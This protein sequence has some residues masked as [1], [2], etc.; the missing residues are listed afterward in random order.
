MLES[1][2]GLGY[3][4]IRERFALVRV[5]V[6]HT[7]R[8]PPS[9]RDDEY[10]YVALSRGIEEVDE[11]GQSTREAGAP[12]TITDLA[13]FAKAL[14][15]TT[16][17]VVMGER[18]AV[19]PGPQVAV[20]PAPGIAQDAMVVRGTL[21]RAISFETEPGGEMS[22]WKGYDFKNLTAEAEAATKG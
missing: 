7:F 18:W 2:S 21:P 13:A 17:V 15:T 14:P 9:T 19:H 1:E 11:N 10:V 6:V 16:R 22:S 20:E 3:P 5:K 4:D 12:T 8:R